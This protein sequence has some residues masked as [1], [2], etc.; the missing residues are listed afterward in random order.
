MEIF[1][2]NIDKNGKKRKSKKIQEGKCHFPFKYKGV[3]YN[4]C[5][6]G[7][8]GNWCAT[9]L[10]KNGSVNTWGFC[11]DKKLPIQ[12]EKKS[13]NASEDK[14]NNY[15][16]HIEK[17][18]IVRHYKNT[19]DKSSKSWS[20]GFTKTENGWLLESKW[21]RLDGKQR[22]SFY[23]GEDVKHAQKK[24]DNKL[25]G[26]YEPLGV[27]FY[28]DPDL[29]ME[30]TLEDIES[31]RMYVSQLKKKKT[32]KIVEN[33][34]SIKISSKGNSSEKNSLSSSTKKS[35]NKKS[36]SSST[37]KSGLSFNREERIQELKN[38]CIDHYDGILFEE[39]EDW[40]DQE[41]EEA[42]LI[43]PEDIKRCY[44][45]ETIYRWI[46]DSIKSGKPLK[47]PINVSHEITEKELN[48]IKN[49]IRKKMGDKYVSP[50]HKQ[51]VLDEKNVELLIS[52]PNNTWE[53]IPK[54]YIPYYGRGALRYPFFHIQIKIS[55]P[56]NSDPK[57]ID[58]GY[59][60]AGIEPMAGEDQYLSSYS[61]IAS[62]RK[63]WD[64][65]KL[66]L[67]HH[68]LNDIKCCTVELNKK[69]H[70]WFD[71]YGRLDIN[72]VSEFGADLRY[73]ELM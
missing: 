32:K 63:L 67:V 5:V 23:V 72:K 3:N 56:G 65:R 24:I 60:P 45:V 44:K 17:D 49:I 1:A 40:E 35:S 52:D 47:D 69:P 20:I 13:S 58:L 22:S 6:K 19:K 50:A 30:A 29:I 18:G 10:T 4:E 54:K 37:K 53:S 42:I 70:Y 27:S 33:K 12:E 7:E 9:S 28:F 66:L 55:I 39:F 64:M 73:Q 2:N 61:L 41:L 62:V 68:P 8:S 34:S 21:G 15:Y 26:N 71:S 51:I 59:I 48:Y 43:G 36:L 38:K 46:E 11:E 14:L 31:V 57:Y 25:L 16:I